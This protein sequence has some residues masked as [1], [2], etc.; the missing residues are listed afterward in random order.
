MAD[1]PSPCPSRM[2]LVFAFLPT[3]PV[4]LGSVI[5]KN[6]G[7]GNVLAERPRPACASV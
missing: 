2:A 5:W 3:E 6:G 4:R 7:I 1:E